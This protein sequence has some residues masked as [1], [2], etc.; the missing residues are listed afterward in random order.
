MEAAFCVSLLVASTLS[1]VEYIFVQKCTS[2]TYT[3]L[4]DLLSLQICMYSARRASALTKL[5]S[6]CCNVNADSGTATHKP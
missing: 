6:H 2:M 5:T 1:I 4:Y 3:Y